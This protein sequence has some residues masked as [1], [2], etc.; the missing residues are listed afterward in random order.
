MPL[1]LMATWRLSG[2]NP[3]R[4]RCCGNDTLDQDLLSQ[5]PSLIVI[6]TQA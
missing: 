3:P 1:V 2:C 4:S 6:A 5:A